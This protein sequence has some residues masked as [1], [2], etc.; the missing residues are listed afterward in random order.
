MNVTTLIPPTML[1]RFAVPCRHD[2]KIG[3]D[4]P[5]ELGTPC[6][7]RGFGELDGAKPFADLRMAWNDQGIGFTLQVT[8]K[9]QAAWCRASR[10]EDSDGLSLFLDTR[11]TQNIHRASRF[12]HRFVFLPY[13][14][15]KQERDPLPY[16]L[17]INRARA[18]PTPVASDDLTLHA[19]QKKG[20]YS[21][22]G[23]I[24]GSALTGFDPS[25]HQQLGFHFSVIDRELGW[26]TFSLG[27]EYPILEDPSLWGTLDL[28][29]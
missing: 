21:L 24:P 25:E 20:G 28:V 11:N 23:F 14:H 6:K 26:H 27:P 9:K 12:C 1:F 15:G 13:G 18:I 19:Q 8:G 3:G 4:G 5:V 2:A 10:I 7:I 22:Q 29:R 16:F 17:P